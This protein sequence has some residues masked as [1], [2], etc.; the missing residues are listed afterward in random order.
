LPG[1]KSFL[2]LSGTNTA[3]VHMIGND[4]TSADKPF[5][6][7]EDVAADAWRQEGNLLP[8]GIHKQEE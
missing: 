1:T 7:D 3:R 6:V 5:S 2:R 8:N 4:F